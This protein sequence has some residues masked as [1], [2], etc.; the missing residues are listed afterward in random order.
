MCVRERNTD[1]IPTDLIA[2]LDKQPY[3]YV[4]NFTCLR[5]ALEWDET[6]QDETRRDETPFVGAAS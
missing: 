5:S 2:R 3:L 1:I 6:R 4:T